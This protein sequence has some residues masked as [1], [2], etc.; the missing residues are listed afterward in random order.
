MARGGP[1]DLKIISFNYTY[2]IV[3]VIMLE[4]FSSKILYQDYNHLHG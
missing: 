4:I 2:A 1:R 3:G